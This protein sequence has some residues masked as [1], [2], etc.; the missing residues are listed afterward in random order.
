MQYKLNTMHITL[1]I[2]VFVYGLMS[3]ATVSLQI[4]TE[5]KYMCLW[6]T[7]PPAATKSQQA[8]FSTKVKVKVIDL[9]VIWKGL[10]S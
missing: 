6:N 1:N 2:I 4:L 10:V 7:M 8:I 3:I 9:G 5:I